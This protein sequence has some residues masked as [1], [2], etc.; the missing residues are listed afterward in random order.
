MAEHTAE[1]YPR[2][3]LSLYDGR[4]TYSAP[5]TVF[6]L[7][8]VSLYFG[9]YYLVLTSTEQVRAF[10]RHFDALIRE[11]AVEARDAPDYLRALARTVS[12]R[13]PPSP[14]PEPQ[15]PDPSWG[16]APGGAQ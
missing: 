4:R 15:R 16:H 10:A 8:R 2:L 1:S 13:G 5:F 14:P 12:D 7:H 3:R 11:A 6:G 9:R